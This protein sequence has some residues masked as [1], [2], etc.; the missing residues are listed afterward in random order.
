MP[1]YEYRCSAC[2]RRTSILVRRVY[3]PPESPRCSHCG[4]DRL[5]RTINRV[6]TLRSEESRMESMADPSSFGDV[7]ENDPASV[8]RW[9]RRMGSEMG[10]DLGDDF[11][12]MV[13]RMEAG[14]MP[15]DMPGEGPDAGG[16]FGSDFGGDSLDM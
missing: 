12:E 10:E 14:E 8:A 6:A 1:I 2:G 13:D 5:Q 3:Q 4:S 9:A 16:D 11:S 15:D 7:D